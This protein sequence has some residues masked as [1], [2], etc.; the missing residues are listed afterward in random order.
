LLLR[1]EGVSREPLTAEDETKKRPGVLPSEA[2]SFYGVNARSLLLLYPIISQKSRRLAMGWFLFEINRYG[3]KV[4]AE[5]IGKSYTTIEAVQK[6]AE[7]SGWRYE[8]KGNLVSIYGVS[9]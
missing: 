9:K 1:G 8:I 2:R 4:A 5:Y 7:V 6:E 3:S